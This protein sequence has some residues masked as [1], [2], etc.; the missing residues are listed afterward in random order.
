MKHLGFVVLGILMGLLVVIWERVH[1]GTVGERFELTRIESLLIDIQVLKFRQ[2]AVGFRSSVTVKLP[3]IAYF[4]DHVEI[5][6]R[7][8]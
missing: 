4:P 3:G 8:Q 2:N 5:Q 1:I 7:Y 6:I